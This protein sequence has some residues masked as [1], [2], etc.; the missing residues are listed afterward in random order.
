MD[1]HHVCS[2]LTQ[3][4]YLSTPPPLHVPF[5]KKKK[6]LVD[7]TGVELTYIGCSCKECEKYA[8]LKV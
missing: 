5:L 7:P 3:I 1:I 6:S 2:D 4:M 8:I